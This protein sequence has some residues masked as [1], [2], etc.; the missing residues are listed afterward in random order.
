ME[1]IPGRN[2]LDHLGPLDRLGSQG[3]LAPLELLDQLD[4]L[5]K[6]DQPDQKDPK[7]HTKNATQLKT[8]SFKKCYQGNHL[9]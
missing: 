5:E 7:V 6:L 9:L 2:E 1:K 3:H 8:E 4:R